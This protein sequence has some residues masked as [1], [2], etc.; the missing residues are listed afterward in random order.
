MDAFVLNGTVYPL[1]QLATFCTPP[2]LSAYEQRV[3]QF[4]QHWLAGQET[5]TLHTSGS[6]GTPK[7]M[8]LTRA[9]MVASAHWTGRALGLQPGDRA[10]VC[11]SIEYIAGLMM[12][13]RGFE[14]GLPLTIIDPA[15]QPLA[16]FAPETHFDF[17]AMVPLQLQTTLHG[18]AH[19]RAIL[20][21][22]KGV[23]I[24]G[25]PVSLALEHHAQQ[26]QA[27]LYHTYGMTETVSH[28]ALRRMNG[29][30]RSDYFVPFD[31]VRL[32]LDARG[33]LTITGAVTRGET[34]HTNDRVEFHPDG[35]FRWLG[36]IDNVINSGGVKVQIEQV[37]TAL[38]AWLCHYQEGYYAA[39][40]FFVGALEDAR[41][42]QAVVAVIEGEPFGG[43]ETGAPELATTIRSHLQSALT[44]YAVP[45]HVYFVP[46][47]LET[48]TGKIDRAA[49]LARLTA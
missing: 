16:A 5:F 4:A 6:T 42:G 44:R 7:A 14:L 36:R 20:D 2:Q 28:V 22:M 46:Q 39:R 49:N 19:E 11:L 40:R 1:Q 35:T 3:I 29:P 24:G 47:L 38:E 32:E 45:R 27:P 25:A 9:Q 15:S 8:Q 12:L 17:T 26:V 43:A 34:L 41:L 10:L 37:E 23:L 30:E 21:R 13:V 33:C 48:P 31:E 18:A